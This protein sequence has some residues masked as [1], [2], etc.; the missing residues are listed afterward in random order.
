MNCYG[1]AK[2]LIIYTEY[3]IDIINIFTESNVCNWGYVSDVI[4]A[5]RTVL[6]A[7]ITKIQKLVI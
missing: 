7:N 5:W 6:L 1:Y 4:E 2:I 3:E